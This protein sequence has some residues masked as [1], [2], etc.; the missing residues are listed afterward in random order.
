[1]LQVFFL[2]VMYVCNGFSS[3][4]KYFFLQVFQMHISS[5]SFVFFCTLQVLDLDV[6]KVD[7]DVGHVAMVFQMLHMFLDVCCKCFI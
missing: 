7:R 5:V 3:V 1:M 4:F 2:D 6:S